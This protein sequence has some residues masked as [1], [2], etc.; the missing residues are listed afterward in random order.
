MLWHSDTHVV[1]HPYAEAFTFGAVL[2][3]RRKAGQQFGE[4]P[5]AF[6]PNRRRNHRQPRKG[7][8]LRASM[9]RIYIFA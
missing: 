9:T 5:R 7:V 6:T 8:D 1:R 2:L 3:E 4:V